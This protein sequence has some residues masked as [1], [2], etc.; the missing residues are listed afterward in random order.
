[1]G[2]IGKEL[3]FHFRYFL[4]DIDI[5]LHFDHEE[6]QAQTEI[7]SRQSKYDI[8]NHCPPTQPPGR[9]NRNG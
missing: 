1:M 8:N 4:L 6:S 5:I 3:N 9:K 2:N 7:K